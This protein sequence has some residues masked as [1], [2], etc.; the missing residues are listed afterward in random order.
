MPRVPL[1]TTVDEDLLK[2]W[3]RVAQEEGR[4]LNWYIEQLIGGFLQARKEQSRNAPA[5]SKPWPML[6][7]F[8][9]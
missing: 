9:R 2:E 4:D 7:K 5:D 6:T 8:L 3:K 1:N